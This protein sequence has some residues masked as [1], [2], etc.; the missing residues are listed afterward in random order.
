MPFQKGQGRV[1]D[2]SQFLTLIDKDSAEKIL[3]TLKGPEEREHREEMKYI[4]AQHDGTQVCQQI[5]L[6]SAVG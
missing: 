5:F 6:C 4:L 3:E 2:K 1:A